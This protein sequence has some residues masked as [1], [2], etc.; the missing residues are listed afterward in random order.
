LVNT[1]QPDRA[2]KSDH[3]HRSLGN[4]EDGHTTHSPLSVGEVPVG[5]SYD[6]FDP[7]P[8]QE[9]VGGKVIH[10]DTTTS[11]TAVLHDFPF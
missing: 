9:I 6:D 5:I 2:I 3:V 8:Y 4:V 1:D 7:V 10:E 11:N